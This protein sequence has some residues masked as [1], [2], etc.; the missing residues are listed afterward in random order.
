MSLPNDIASAWAD[1]DRVLAR[2]RAEPNLE[3]RRLLAAEAGPLV[4]RVDALMKTANRA[5]AMLQ[6]VSDRLV[7]DAM[8]KIIGLCEYWPE[9]EAEQ[10]ALRAD[11]GRK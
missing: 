10:A 6:A 8:S 4:E 1:H 2:L 3:R 5:N 7:G 9:V 11:G